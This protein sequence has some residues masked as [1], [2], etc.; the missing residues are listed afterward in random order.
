MI[1]ADWK[2]RLL[3]LLS[4]WFSCT[5]AAFAGTVVFST[6]DPDWSYNDG[7][8]EFPPGAQGGVTRK[9]EFLRLDGNFARGGRYVSATLA[10]KFPGARELRFKVRSPAARLTVLLGGADG[11]VRRVEQTLNGGAPEFREIAVPLDGTAISS[12]G[13]LLNQNDLRTDDG[14][15]E[16][17]GVRFVGVPDG[18]VVPVCRADSDDA[19]FVTPGGRPF[20]LAVLAGPETFSPEALR[21]RWLDY[22]GKEAASGTAAFDAAMR[23]ISVPAPA[24]AGYFELEFPGSGIRSAVVAAESY[25]GVTDGFFGIDLPAGTADFSGWMRLLRRC[26]IGWC[27]DRMAWPTGSVEERYGTLRAAAAA[28]EISVLDTFEEGALRSHY[29]ENLVETARNFAVFAVRPDCGKAVEIASAFGEGVSP[30]FE[31]APLRAVST[32]FGL[33]KILLPL[34]GGNGALVAD[35]PVLDVYRMYVAAGLLDDIDVLSFSA[36]EPAAGLEEEVGLMRDI[37]KTVRSGRAGIPY[38]VSA[39]GDADPVELVVRAVELRA[40]G[41]AKYF[42]AAAG[43]TGA[44]REPLRPFGVYA[45]LPRVLAFKEYLGDLKIEGATRSRAFSDGR[46]VV[47]CLF[48]ADGAKEL[49]LPEGLAVLRAAGIDG[50]P[51]EIRN[52]VVPMGD[53]V[54]FLYPAPAGF[55]AFL[56]V[57]TPAMKLRKVA[58]GFKPAERS[59]KPVVIQSGCDPAAGIRDRIASRVFCGEPVPYRM[60]FSNLSDQTVTVEPFL[61]LP[62]GVRAI[63]RPDFSAVAKVERPKLEL[64]PGSRMEYEFSLWFDPSLARRA[65]MTFPVGDRGGKATS[66]V[67]PVNPCDRA[68]VE[69]PLSGRLTDWIDFS[70]TF[71]WESGLRLPVDIR[72]KFRV[73]ARPSRLRFEIEVREEKRI[74]GDG[75]RLALQLRRDPGDCSGPLLRFD[76]A[77]PASGVGSVFSRVGD[78]ISRY[79][80]DVPAPALGVPALEKGMCLGV[81]LA[82]DSGGGEARRGTLSWGEGGGEK[83]IPQLF[84]LLVF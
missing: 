53:K 36:R 78:G 76:S 61:N 71:N 48:V 69:V 23:T 47:V 84:Q 43:M 28:E 24:A 66:L 77:R 55:A 16:I 29:S 37:E 15:L 9:S 63:E 11:K 35:D 60:F 32:R 82:A 40:L 19:Y 30:E 10:M 42:P 65:P 3:P 50:R 1:A 54:V 72:A 45:H 14:F 57:D 4:L 44:N 51:L 46:D 56:N 34:A 83:T 73:S 70:S 33:D 64:L 81:F 27:R 52:G 59:V 17:S 2:K 31:I 6:A 18:K 22:T 38:W 80:I 5:L 39:P 74:R 21:F 25:A 13:F 75:V 26:G 58:L 49:R 20:R 79:V 7:S 62:G 12:V 68:R 8:A 67:V 41:G